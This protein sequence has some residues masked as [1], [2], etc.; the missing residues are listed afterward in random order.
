MGLEGKKYPARPCWPS[1]LLLGT[2]LLLACGLAACA[3]TTPS[4]AAVKEKAASCVSGNCQNGKG[5]WRQPAGNYTRVSTGTFK[6]G[7][8][9]E[10]KVD[11]A[12]ANMDAII[13]QEV[14]AG[15]V[16]WERAKG[17]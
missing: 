9:W 15:K 12:L 3:G 5:V 10:G 1:F 7:K 16:V 4:R 6:E 13:I 8:L 11:E 14:V 2:A 17:H